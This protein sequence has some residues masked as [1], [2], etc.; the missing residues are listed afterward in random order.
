[1]SKVMKVSDGAYRLIADAAS[2]NQIYL[3]DALDNMLFNESNLIEEEEED[4]HGTFDVASDLVEVDHFSD[5]RQLASQIKAI[6]AESDPCPMCGADVGWSGLPA[7][8][9]FLAF[10]LPE[11]YYR[12]CPECHKEKPVAN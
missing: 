12:R 8:R 5:G 10:M 1:M 6:E 4:N 11:K 7:R 3:I 9:F 2:R